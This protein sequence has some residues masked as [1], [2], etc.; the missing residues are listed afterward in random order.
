MN[1]KEALK[2]ICDKCYI[3]MGKRQVACPFRSIDNEYCEKY[4]IIK[5][6]LNRL[7]KLEKE[8]KELRS[9]IKS[10]NVNGGNLLRE[11]TKLKEIIKVFVGYILMC[12]PIDFDTYLNS[13][14]DDTEIKLITELLK[15]VL[16][17]D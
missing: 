12:K 17:N 1:S 9:S 6:D 3:E 4:E 8:N 15:E 2:S 7:E 5:Q 14:C 13:F 10:W 16:G 11:N